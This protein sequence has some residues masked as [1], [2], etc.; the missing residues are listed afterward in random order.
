MLIVITEE[1]A[2]YETKNWGSQGEIYINALHSI[3]FC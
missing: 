2:N 1:L 3:D